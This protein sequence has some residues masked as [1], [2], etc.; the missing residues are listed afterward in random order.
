MATQHFKQEPIAPA[1]AAPLLARALASLREAFR[2]KTERD[3]ME[4]YLA[5]S[6]DI[7][8][9]EARMRAWDSR[10]SGRRGL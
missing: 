4:A 2:V 7:Y 6:A 10:G 3:I 9:L 5:G 1:P 8:E